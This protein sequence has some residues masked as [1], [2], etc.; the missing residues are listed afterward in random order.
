MAVTLD[1]P[2]VIP[3]IN[4]RTFDEVWVEKLSIHSPM[5]TEGINIQ[6]TVFGARTVDSNTGQKE[7]APGSRRLLNFSV[8][9]TDMTQDELTLMY[10]LVTMLK[11]RM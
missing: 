2:I 6:A 5:N 8:K 1:N 9:W 11:S 7:S 3:A 4:Q 10:Q